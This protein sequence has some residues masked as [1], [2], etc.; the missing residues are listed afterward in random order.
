MSPVSRTNGVKM[1]GSRCQIYGAYCLSESFAR[2][3]EDAKG[4]HQLCEVSADSVKRCI[5]RCLQQ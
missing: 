3:E 1:I 5:L 2:C 4:W